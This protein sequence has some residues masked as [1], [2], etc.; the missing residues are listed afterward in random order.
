MTFNTEEEWAAAKDLGWLSQIDLQYHWDNHGYGTFEDFLTQLKASKRKSIRQERKGVAKQ[1]L[2]VR[3]LR[4]DEITAEVWDKFYDF[5]IDTSGAS[6][7]LLSRFGFGLPR[8]GAC[9]W[10]APQSH[11]KW[12][13]ALTARPCMRRAFSSAEVAICAVICRSFSGANLEPYVALQTESG[14][15]HT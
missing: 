13:C 9:L 7:P 1:G 14:A 2:T 6:R 11:A 15:L 4:G 5:Y 10:R 3:R 8:S 12:R